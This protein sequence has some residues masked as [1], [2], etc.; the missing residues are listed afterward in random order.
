LEAGILSVYSKTRFKEQSASQVSFKQKRRTGDYEQL[1]S[2]EIRNRLISEEA[3]Q[4]GFKTSYVS[5]LGFQ[6]SGLGA[7]ELS[8]SEP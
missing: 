3:R 4:T 8:K 6:D 2:K 7:L 1:I 5:P